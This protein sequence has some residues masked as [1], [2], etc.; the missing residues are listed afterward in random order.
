MNAS[1]R[2]ALYGIIKELESIQASI[3]EARNALDEI[4]CE[5]QDAL[6][7]LPESIQG[8]N[9]GREMEEY[10]DAME[11]ASTDL[12]DIDIGIIIEALEEIVQ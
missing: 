8:S 10:I 5:E 11:T 12:E 2:K 6:D 9:R 3:E 1:R 7:N 4:T